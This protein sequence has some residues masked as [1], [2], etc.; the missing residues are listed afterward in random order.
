MCFPATPYVIPRASSFATVVGVDENFNWDALEYEELCDST[1]VRALIDPLMD[2]ITPM[3]FLS[4]PYGSML[5]IA[6]GIDS[7]RN[8]GGGNLGANYTEADRAASVVC[9]FAQF[10]G[11]LWLAITLVFVSVFASCAGVCGMC[12]LRSV[13]AVRGGNAQMDRYEDAVHDLLVANIDS[14]QLADPGG[15]RHLRLKGALTNSKRLRARRVRLQ[16]N[17]I[18]VAPKG[19]A[20]LPQEP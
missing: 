13:R 16:S 20:L 7:I 8:L 17:R 19:H 11:V 2:R 10:G 9:G 1:A 12:C 18:Q 4:A 3:G 14:G 5:R 6:E 15:V